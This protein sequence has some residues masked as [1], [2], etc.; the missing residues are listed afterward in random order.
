MNNAGVVQPKV[1][2]ARAG[3]LLSP[4]RGSLSKCLSTGGLRPRLNPYR[5][6]RAKNTA[7]TRRPVDLNHA[8]MLNGGA[9]RNCRVRVGVR[10]RAS[11][12]GR[13]GG[14]PGPHAAGRG[15]A[16]K[17]HLRLSSGSGMAETPSQTGRIRG[18]AA[19][20]RRRE[21]P[22]VRPCAVRPSGRREKLTAENAEGA[23]AR[24]SSVGGRVSGRTRPGNNRRR[25]G[26]G[27]GR[28]GGGSNA[29]CLMAND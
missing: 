2:L 10:V 29:K 23:E 8:K 4:R 11:A 15:G 27:R 13:R 28:A 24:A 5:P 25:R 14:T 18:R 16:R 19:R 17:S 3:E 20:C 6:F 1:T 22:A 26:R 7:V 9:R 12:H 21:A